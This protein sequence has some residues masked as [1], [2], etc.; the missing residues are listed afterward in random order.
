MSH[1]SCHMSHG[2]T[3]LELL[4]VIAIIAVIIG[5]A[6]PNFLGARER[7]RDYKRKA[8]LLELKTAL[9]L[10]F[11][12]YN[13]YPS[14]S[15]GL[16]IWG[17]GTSGGS[18]CPACTTAEFAAGGAD[19]CGT[20]YMR[21]LPKSTSGGVEYRYYQT[22]AGDDFRLKVTLENASD[23]DLATSQVKCPTTTPVGSGTNINYGATD[24]VVCAD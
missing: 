16:L 17:C 4:V 13:K 2:F 10:Y 23:P 8:E 7:A 20:I 11:S 12:D 19:G 22:N 15:N 24:Y 14:W 3:L 6:L 21:R 18:V 9:R 1:V 5:L